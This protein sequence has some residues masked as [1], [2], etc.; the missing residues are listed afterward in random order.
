MS[1]TRQAA[2]K[3]LKSIKQSHSKM[4]GIEYTT[5][6]KATYLSS[7]V[8]NSESIK[9]LFALKTQT[10]EGIRNYFR[11]MYTKLSDITKVKIC[12]VVM[13]SI[14]MYSQTIKYCRNK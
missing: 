7:P 9:V 1:E 5:F 4:D 13:Y 14:Q 6:E 12:L 2:F 10:L 3:Y 8:F 11:G